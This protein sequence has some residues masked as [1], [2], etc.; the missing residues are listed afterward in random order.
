METG[1]HEANNG[2]KIL[3]TDLECASSMAYSAKSLYESRLLACMQSE[4][5]ISEE[6]WKFVVL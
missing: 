3:P 2:G 1:N 4:V 5:K 6:L